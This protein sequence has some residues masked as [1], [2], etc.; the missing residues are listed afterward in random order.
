MKYKINYKFVWII[1]THLLTL[2]KQNTIII[3]FKIIDINIQINMTNK[4]KERIDLKKI[5]KY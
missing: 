1:K 2:N 4:K 3:I 5:K